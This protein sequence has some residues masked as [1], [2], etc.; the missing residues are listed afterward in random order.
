MTWPSCVSP[1]PRSTPGSGTSTATSSGSS[2]ALRRAEAE[3]CDVALFP[4]LAITGYPPEDLLLKPGFVADNQRA[5]ERIAAATSALRGGGRLR[6]TTTATSGTRPRC[7]PA[8]RSSGVYRKCELPNYAVFDELRYFAR[9]HQPEQLYRIAGV[10]RRR[11]DLRGRLEPVGP[12][13]RPGRQRRR[14]DPQPQRLAL[15][16]GQAGPAGADARHPRRRRVLR[17]R[18]RE[19]GRRP[20]RA[21]L[22]RRVA[23]P[24]TPTAS[25]SP[26]R[27]SSSRTCW[28]STS[29]CSPCTASGSSTRVAGRPTS[30]S[31]WSSWPGSPTSPRRRPIRP[32]AGTAPIADL[33]GCDEEVYEALVLGTRDYVEK[34]GFSDVVIGLSGG[35]DS[36]LVA[37]IAVDALGA[38]RVHGVSMPSRYSSDHSR[39]DA[40]KLASN[41]GHR[42]PHDRHRAR[43]RRACSRCWR[44]RSRV[45][46]P[47]SPRRTCS[48]ASAARC[49]WRCRTSSAGSC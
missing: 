34:N 5:L 46:N 4:E 9:G 15:R 19:P 17:A 25:C 30:S 39:S 26:A 1:P 6:R 48:P 16:R 28:S 23:S 24:S 20:G 21:G 32:S 12:D 44:R 36:T 8:A 43:A 42:L 33:L 40:E 38:D 10:P 31:R 47:T 3:G 2:T 7:A 29:T 49:S 27:P 35:I 45:A 37:V 13:R 11:V 22:R 18:L 41:L 14:G